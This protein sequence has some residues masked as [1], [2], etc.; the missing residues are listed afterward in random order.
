MV[1]GWENNQDYVYIYRCCN[2][3]GAKGY[4]SKVFLDTFQP[5]KPW[6]GKKNNYLYCDGHVVARPP[7]RYTT[8]SLST[9]NE[10]YEWY[11]DKAYYQSIFEKNWASKVPME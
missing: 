7:G 9:Y 2:W 4:Y 5:G 8:G 3:M 10:M 11:V 1:S 6:H